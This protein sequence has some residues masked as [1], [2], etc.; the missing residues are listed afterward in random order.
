M[1][2]NW[3]VRC[4]NKLFWLAFIPAFCVLI[5]LVAALFGFELDLTFYQEKLLDI[6]NSVFIIL[7]LLGIVTDPTTKGVFDS[8]QALEY[9]KPRE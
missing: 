8:A 9:E 3:K 7:A 6:V 4:K 1:N 5:Q 2:I